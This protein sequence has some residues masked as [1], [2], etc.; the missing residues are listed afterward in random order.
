[1]RAVLGCCGNVL[2]VALSA[3]VIAGFYRRL[4]SVIG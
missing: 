3:V 4:E 2:V 1:L